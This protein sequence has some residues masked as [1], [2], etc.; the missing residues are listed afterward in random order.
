[1]IDRLTASEGT[2]RL[3]PVATKLNSPCPRGPALG[4]WWRCGGSAVTEQAAEII[5][6]F[7]CLL[8]N[9]KRSVLGQI[10]AVSGTDLYGK[11]GDPKQNQPEHEKSYMSFIM[12]RHNFPGRATRAT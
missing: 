8:E 12:R 7:C 5:D 1:M 6:D 4:V 9:N 3:I 2:N 10:L 11:M